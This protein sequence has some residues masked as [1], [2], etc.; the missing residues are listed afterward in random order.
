MPSATATCTS[1]AHRK[2]LL[3]TLEHRAAPSPEP[4]ELRLVAGDSPHLEIVTSTDSKAAE[5]TQAVHELLRCEGPMSRTSLRQQLRIP[6]STPR[7]SAQLVAGAGKHTT[8]RGRMVDQQ[9]ADP[10]RDRAAPCPTGVPIPP[11]RGGRERNGG[12][13][14]MI[15]P[16]L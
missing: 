5:L 6:K 4:L 11:F 13:L 9:R 14:W 1:G 7:S 3:L 12:H 15:Q 2:Q 10:H 8:Y 16:H